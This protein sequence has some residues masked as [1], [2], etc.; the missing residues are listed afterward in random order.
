MLRR[1]LGAE[2][3]RHR[4][5]T[6]PRAVGQDRVDRPHVVRHQAITDR[7]RAA[8]VVAR[9]AADGAARMGRGIDREEQPVPAQRGV[10]VRRAR[11]RARPAPCAAAGS[12]CST[13]RRCFEQSIT[14]ARFTVWP[15]WLVPP[16]RGSTGMPCLARDR[17]RGGDVV[18]GLRHDHAERLDLVDRG[19]GGVTAAVGAVEQHLA[20]DFAGQALRKAR[21][22]DSPWAGSS[23]G[24]RAHD[25]GAG[26]RAVARNVARWRGRRQRQG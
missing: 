17:Q 24:G 3:V 12:T 16:P 9:H 26:S 19:V 25:G 22:G 15:H 6:M 7:L 5:E 4:A 23:A 10:Q 11:G 21:P 8:G 13:R 1:H 18:D 14:S 2:I 20:A